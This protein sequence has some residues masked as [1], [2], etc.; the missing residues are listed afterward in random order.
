VHFEDLYMLGFKEDEKQ[1]TP[2]SPPIGGKKE[3]AMNFFRDVLVPMENILKRRIKKI[4]QSLGIGI[5]AVL[6]VGLCLMGGSALLV[7]DSF[8]LRQSYL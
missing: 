1:Q 8:S 2:G 6:T 3:Q 5:T 7:L 4:N